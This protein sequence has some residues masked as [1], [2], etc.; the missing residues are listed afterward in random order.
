MP[1]QPELLKR[2]DDMAESFKRTAVVDEKPRLVYLAEETGVQRG[3]EALVKALGP[4]EAVRFL[5]LPRQRLLDYM[6]W[7]RQWQTSLDQKS[8]FDA[9]FEVGNSTL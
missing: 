7:H 8:F 9:V 2:L 5:S 4:V 1:T 3:V 6:Q